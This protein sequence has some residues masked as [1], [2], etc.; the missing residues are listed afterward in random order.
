MTHQSSTPGVDYTDPERATMFGSLPVL[1]YYVS[2]GSKGS[3]AR[4][5]VSR[6]DYLS[7][8][9]PGLEWLEAL[10]THVAQFSCHCPMSLSNVTVLVARARALP[11]DRAD[12]LAP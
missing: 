7:A 5:G 1:K 9:E 3:L 10:T 2:N 4:V 12:D 8:T 6:W 11:C